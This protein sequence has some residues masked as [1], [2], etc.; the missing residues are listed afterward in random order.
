MDEATCLK[1]EY[2][3]DCDTEISDP[4]GHRD[5][6]A[7]T[8]FEGEYCND[9]DTELSDPL[10]HDAG[11]WQTLE[12]GSQELRCTRCGH[13]LDTKAAPQK[14]THIYYGLRGDVNENGVIDARDYFLLKR[15][16]FGT[17]YLDE[18][19]TYRADVNEN[20]EVDARDYFLLKRNFFNTYVIPN[21]Y[22]YIE[23][24]EE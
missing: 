17:Y 24:V 9:C 18:G 7:A 3:N 14:D 5:V 13:L 16:F 12:D 21:P 10:G 22:V 2:C 8:C 1:G 23:I 15:G 11:E 6:D 20:G 4:L 19:A